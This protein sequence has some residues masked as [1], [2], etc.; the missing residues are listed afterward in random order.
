MHPSTKDSQ[1]RQFLGYPIKLSGS[2]SRNSD[3]RLREAKEILLLCVTGKFIFS[4]KDNKIEIEVNARSG[5]R[6]TEK[7]LD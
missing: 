7:D 3:L 2:E 4:F 1:R 6:I 5:V